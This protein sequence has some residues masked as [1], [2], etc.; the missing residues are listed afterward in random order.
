MPRFSAK[1][2]KRP[3]IPKGK[4]TKYGW[5]V[6][7][8]RHFG[9]GRF[10]DLGFGVYIQSEEGVI[11]EDHVQIG[12]GV[13]IYSVNTIDGT[14]GKIIIK[15]NARIGANSV[16]LPNVEIGENSLV[17]ALSLVNCS[18]PPNEMWGGVPAHQ[19]GEISDGKRKVFGR[20][21]TILNILARELGARRK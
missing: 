16:I 13:K 6:S 7:H 8:P 21:R 15:R 18:I 11:I 4:P 3:R 2:W 9:L 5:V 20:V 14:K 1:N 10:T 19:I 17:G 12:G